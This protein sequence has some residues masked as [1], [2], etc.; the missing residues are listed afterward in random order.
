MPRREDERAG[1]FHIVSL[2][3]AREDIHEIIAE[4]RRGI[5]VHAVIRPHYGVSEAAVYI[6]EW[7]VA[8]VAE[9]VRYGQLSQIKANRFRIEY[10]N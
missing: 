7:L 8:E 1:R 2:R 6:A 4:L 10:G 5:Q 9:A 3:D